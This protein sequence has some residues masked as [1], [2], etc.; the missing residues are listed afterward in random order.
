MS[1]TEILYVLQTLSTQEVLYSSNV[2]VHHS[3][4]KLKHLTLRLTAGKQNTLRFGEVVNLLFNYLKMNEMS[5]QNKHFKI[6]LKVG[7]FFCR[8]F[9]FWKKFFFL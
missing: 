6:I 4:H 7:R 5:I 8:F 3:F 9:H 1:H 2:Y